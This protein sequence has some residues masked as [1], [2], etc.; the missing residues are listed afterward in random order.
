LCD[1]VKAVEEQVVTDPYAVARRTARHA[2]E[3]LYEACLAETAKA[4]TAVT[5]IE[6]LR[7][8]PHRE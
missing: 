2:A 3:G 7:S 4:K 1:R 5:E 6:L 8:S